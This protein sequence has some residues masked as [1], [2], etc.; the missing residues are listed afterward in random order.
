MKT[1]VPYFIL[2]VILLLFMIGYGVA[3]RL[4]NDI[5]IITVTRKERI[6]S[7]DRNRRS[8]Y[9]VWTDSETFECSDSILFLKFNSSD[10]YGKLKIGHKYKVLVAGWRI[11]IFSMY[12]N[13]ITIE[14]DKK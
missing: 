7:V 14:E 5:I 1:L 6:V 3:Y 8:K 9:L 13:I 10:I 11:P 2:V 4:S 12:R